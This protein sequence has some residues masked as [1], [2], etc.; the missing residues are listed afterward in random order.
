MRQQ[1][2]FRLSTF[3]SLIVRKWLQGAVNQAFVCSSGWLLCRD[4]NMNYQMIFSSGT[5]V[6]YCFKCFSFVNNHLRKNIVCTYCKEKCF[7]KLLWKTL[8]RVKLCCFSVWY[9]T[10]TIHCTVWRLSFYLE[11]H[12]MGKCTLDMTEIH[13][14]KNW[15]G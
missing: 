10:Y 2:S 14:H 8:H 3:A 11:V 5:D 7:T 12:L 15:Y 9:K 13:Q 1:M 6:F 4:K